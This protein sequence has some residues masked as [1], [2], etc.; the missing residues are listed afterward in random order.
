MAADWTQDE[1]QEVR[2]QYAGFTRSRLEARREALRARI[3]AST[4][5]PVQPEPI[6]PDGASPER[7]RVARIHFAVVTALLRTA[8]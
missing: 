2:T 3:Q 5:L 6:V 7:A 4:A 1:W 8:R